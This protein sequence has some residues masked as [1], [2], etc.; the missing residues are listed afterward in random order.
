[1]SET[2]YWAVVVAGVAAF[3]ASSVWYIL[4]G[5]ERMKLLGDDPAATADMKKVP[6]WKKPVELFRGL[7]VAYV[8][9]RFIVLL[10]V[11]DWKGAVQLGIWVWIGFPAM[12]LVGSVLWD[13]RPWKLAAIHAGDWLLKI[14]LMAVILAVWR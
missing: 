11:A 3:A 2:N 8:L 13:N 5:K 7:V 9:A 12:I 10:G 6:A 1:M 14:L 4:F